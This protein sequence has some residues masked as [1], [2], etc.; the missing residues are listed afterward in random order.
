MRTFQA[1]VITI[2]PWIHQ[3]FTLDIFVRYDGKAASVECYAS[4]GVIMPVSL[5]TPILV[6]ETGVNETESRRIITFP[7][8]SR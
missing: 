3:N 2:V 8:L 1:G 4:A 7:E 6:P 5:G